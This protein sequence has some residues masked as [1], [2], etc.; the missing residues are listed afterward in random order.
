M[1]VWDN[2]DSRKKGSEISS[3]VDTIPLEG[4]EAGPSSE[5]VDAGIRFLDSV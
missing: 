4:S 5:Q 3:V 1:I 2:F